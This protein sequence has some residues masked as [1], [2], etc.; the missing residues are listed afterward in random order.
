MSRLGKLGMS[1]AAMRV[2]HCSSQDVLHNSRAESWPYGDVGSISWL[3]CEKPQ[4]VAAGS[5]L[6]GALDAVASAAEPSIVALQRSVAKAESTESGR[7]A[8]A[9]AAPVTLAPEALRE[10][11]R[12]VA[13]HMPL[14]EGRTWAEHAAAHTAEAPKWRLA[15]LGHEVGAVPW[16][17]STFHGCAGAGPS[18]FPLAGYGAFVKVLAP[19]EYAYFAAVHLSVV[20][21]AGGE[22]TWLRTQDGRSAYRAVAAN[23]LRDCKL[24]SGQ[25]VWL[26]PAWL[27]IVVQAEAQARRVDALCV[28]FLHS[29]PRVISTER[30]QNMLSIKK[31]PCFRRRS[32]STWGSTRSRRA[33]GRWAAARS[34]PCCAG[35]SSW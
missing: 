17:Q 18:V 13:L 14:L 26:P 12:A 16:L 7:A 19:A 28:P 9:A 34:R 11:M 20:A 6:A 21:S 30:T 22:S 27:C 10:L 8:G 15:P 5:A 23:K 32:C 35:S 2:Q 4:R 29:A 3:E 25:W 24:P 1:A 31:C 33:R